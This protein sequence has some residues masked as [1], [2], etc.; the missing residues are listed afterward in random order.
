MTDPNQKPDESQD[1][2]ITC[3]WPTESGHEWGS[4]A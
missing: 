3:D 4:D 1:E 2:E